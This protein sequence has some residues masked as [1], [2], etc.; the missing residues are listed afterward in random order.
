MGSTPSAGMSRR[1]MLFLMGGV[2]VGI[3]LLAS[4]TGSGDPGSASGGGAGPLTWWDHKSG[5]WI[6]PTLDRVMDDNPGLTVAREEYPASE[7]V[8]ALQLGRRSDQMPDVHTAHPNLGPVSVLVQ[9]GWFQPLGDHIDLS[10]TVVADRLVEGIHIFDGKVY[11]FPLDDGRSHEQTPWVVSDRLPVDVDPADARSWDGFRKVARD[12]TRD[13]TYAIAF[14]GQ[15][16]NFLDLKLRQLA[17]AAGATHVGGVDY[18]TGEYVFDSTPFLDA[19]EFLLA[20]QSDG[21]FHPSLGSMGPEDAA[22]RWAA[23]E[24]HIHWHGPWVPGVVTNN[25]PELLDMG[26]DAWRM[27]GPEGEP[28]PVHFPPP[29]G[30]FW[31]SNAS[32]RPEEAAAAIAAFASQETFVAMANAMASPPVDESAVQ[33]AD[34]MEP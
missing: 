14:A 30:E 25:Y 28:S 31:I 13:N 2:A 21:V 20:L 3:P 18:S 33:A 8:K 27:P 10:G 17:S 5:V 34:V 11:S 4:C 16:P 7:L 6:T 12:I 24:A 19:V 15:G 29:P 23:G 22:Q 26:F 1:Q 32:Q 9:E